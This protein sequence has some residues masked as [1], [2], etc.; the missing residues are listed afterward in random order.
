MQKS[1]RESHSVESNFRRQIFAP[2]EANAA[3]YSV[4][5]AAWSFIRA[6]SRATESR[7]LVP[8]LSR[9]AIKA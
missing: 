7:T 4:C 3:L 9:A 6:H 2:A 1:A 8:A 5:P